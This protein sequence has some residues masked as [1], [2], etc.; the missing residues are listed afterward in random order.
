VL[1]GER[2]WWFGAQGVTVERVRCSAGLGDFGWGESIRN[3]FGLWNRRAK[4]PSKLVL[5]I[6]VADVE[7][8]VEHL[9][10]CCRERLARYSAKRGL[11]DVENLPRD[12]APG[13]IIAAAIVHVGEDGVESCEIATH[14]ALKSPAVWQT[15]LGT[16]LSQSW[17]A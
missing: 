10:A 6:P 7:K 17:R 16:L 3:S 1:A 15:W 5:G 4:Y 11:H 12:I 9:P 8:L 2:W 13:F 14:G